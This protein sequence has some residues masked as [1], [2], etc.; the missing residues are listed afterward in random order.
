MIK[1]TEANL[2][3]LMLKAFLSQRLGPFRD[4]QQLIVLWF[5]IQQYSR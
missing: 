2:V 5:E 4:I 3:T 1:Y